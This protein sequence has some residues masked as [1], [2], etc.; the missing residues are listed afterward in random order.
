MQIP[1]TPMILES[2]RELIGPAFLIGVFVPLV[3]GLVSSRLRSV[4]V[5]L[6]FV[7]SLLVGNYLAGVWPGW[8]PS[9]RRI[10]WVA[11]SAIVGAFAGLLIRQPPTR[12]V[13]QALWAAAAA[14]LVV[15]VIPGAS[16]T[17]PVW[18]VPSFVLL[19]GLIA[20]G[21]LRLSEV[22]PGAL[23]PLVM[24][25]SLGAAGAVVIHAHSKS[26][27]DVAVV[28]GVCFVG[29]ASVAVFTKADCGAAMPGAA[30]LLVG[31]LYA[32]YHETDSLVPKAAFVLPALAPVVALVGS[33]PAL[34]RR[35]PRTRNAA[36]LVPVL[37]VLLT[38]VAL[39][40]ANET[41][42]FEVDEY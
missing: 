25:M 24:A 22:R 15:R 38:A 6:A 30:L 33:I 41:L 28:G 11:W 31:V 37:V 27:M 39:A 8:W 1:P 12:V 2:L 21:M 23:V 14:V 17:D 3:C 32:G 18:L 34:E 26:V 16:L 7:A 10:S 5:V 13:G 36:V 9:G 40:A 20:H 35:G 42:S 19:A 4:G 29:I